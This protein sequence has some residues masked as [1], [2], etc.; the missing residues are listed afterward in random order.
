MY[1]VLGHGCPAWS[2]AQTQKL[3][4]RTGRRTYHVVGMVPYG[5]TVYEDPNHLFN[6]KHRP[7]LAQY[8]TQVVGTKFDPPVNFTIRVEVCSRMQRRPVRLY[9]NGCRGFARGGYL[10]AD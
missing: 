4:L 2:Q 8:L 6:R 3:R 1:S 9:P 7:A 5:G 10:Y